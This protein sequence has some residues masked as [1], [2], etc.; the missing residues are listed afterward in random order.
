MVAFDEMKDW[1]I[2]GWPIVLMNNAIARNVVFPTLALLMAGGS[3]AAI[4][5][6]MCTAESAVSS[7][8]SLSAGVR[9][10][11]DAVKDA[12]DSKFP[13]PHLAGVTLNKTLDI[14][15][16]VDEIHGA[17]YDP[18]KGEIVF[19]GQGEI[20][21]NERIDMDD[22]VVAVRS[23]FGMNQDPGITFYSKPQVMQQGRLDVHYFGA[24]KN[25]E[26]GQILFEA[27]YLL[28]QLTLGI[29]PTGQQL[30]AARPGMAALG[31]ESF[32]DRMI[33]EEMSL[34]DYAVEFWFAPKE[35]EVEP[36][37]SPADASKS[38]V[39]SAM[40]M[41][42]YPRVIRVSDGSVAAD[43]Q[44][45]P[46]DPLAGQIFNV[47]DAFATNITNNY[48]DYADL[49][50]FGVLH[51]LKRLGR[52][53]SVVRW[54]RFNDIAVDLSF[55][56]DYV[57]QN[58]STPE[59]VDM[60]Q[61]CRDHSQDGAWASGAC[62]LVGKISGG[63]VYDLEY[64]EFD[65]YD[66]PTAQQN[67]MI[68]EALASAGR[69]LNPQ[70]ANDM[71]WAFTA[72]IGGTPT[73]LV[74]IA[75][76]VAGSEKDGNYNFTV[77]D[78]A[79]P[80]Q[81]GRPL[82]FTRYYDSF[83]SVSSGFGPG[84]SELPYTLRF[85]EAPSEFVWCDDP[86][87]NVVLATL[88]MRRDLI[89]V[90]REHGAT[91]L[92]Q[93]AGYISWPEGG[94]TVDRPY[95]LSAKTGDFIHAR[96]D[97]WFIYY[98]VNTNNQV[99]QQVWFQD[100]SLPSAPRYTADPYH[101]GIPGGG[102]SGGVEQGIWVDYQYDADDRLISIAGEGGVRLIQIDHDGDRI[103]RVW[104]PSAS[105]VRDVVYSY[106]DGRL[107]SATRSSGHVMQYTY[108]SN[109]PSDGAISTVLDQS[110]AETLGSVGA[111]LENRAA[112]AMAEGNP[113]LAVSVFYD[114]P[115]RLVQT[116]DT[117]GRVSAH[118][119]DEQHRL[120]SRSVQ[121]STGQGTQ[122]LGESYA[123]ADPNPLAGPTSITDARGNVTT[124][125]YDAAGNVTSI[126]DAQ[127]RTTT[128]ERGVDTADDMAVVVVTDAKGRKSAQKMDQFSRV[129][130]SYRRIQV[131][132]K[133][134][135]VENGT[136]TGY[137]NF[138]FSSAA[139][140][141]TSYAYDPDSGGVSAVT[142]DSADL[143]GQYPWIS[144]NETTQVGARDGFGQATLVTSPAGYATQYSYD[145]LA[146]MTAVKGPSD[147]AP[148]SF[149]YHAA[150]LA[151]DRVS[152]VSSAAGVSRH[153]YDVANR[154]RR[155]T[156]A[157]GIT[158]SYFYNMKNQ[159]ERVT[160]TAGS[161][162]LTTQYFYDN[163]GRLQT[164]QLPNGTRVTY[165]HDGFDRMI[166][167]VEQESGDA[168]TGNASPVLT[169][170]PPPVSTVAGGGTFTFDIDASDADDDDRR[171]SLVDAPEGMV[172][173]PQTGVI[174]WTP[175]ASQA[176]RHEVVVQVSDGNG[177]VD[178]V[179]FVVV[180]DDAFAPGADNCTAIPNPDQRDTDGDGYGNA[181]DADLNNDGIVNFSDLA[182]FKAAY[183]TADPHADF[184][185]D[186]IVDNQ[187]LDLLKSMFGQP[188]GPSGVA[189]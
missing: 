172:I 113:A 155:T 56:D 57:P 116:T 75:Q 146:R 51:K 122:T 162:T 20:P 45:T 81:A 153:S 182:I 63:I 77:V 95:Y 54:L 101:I 50:G 184:N 7:I 65:G 163:F 12:F 47:A 189:P 120:L 69:V 60:L 154:V 34:G 3:G 176:G 96:A 188:P 85:M 99:V 28:K 78:L 130:E 136:P 35:V 10:L 128:I 126:K 145:G 27:D 167:M 161:A 33:D 23:V 41:K 91:R 157:R 118:Q 92:F 148:V 149:N 14:L 84:W 102:S 164:K 71:K 129:V 80:N 1:R 37:V 82:A 134:P 38:F 11:A 76:T 98:R 62:L 147:V 117:L 39:F 142:R 43:G 40:T 66:Q 16:G 42:V 150:G 30:T 186:G 138:T 5:Q 94:A 67:A 18:R 179:D 181:C 15:N 119:R 19:I 127:N 151:Q 125:T 114:R 178:T 53:T 158:S 177:G 180:A 175:D 2:R 93:A 169:S 187:D 133:T 55:M 32:A 17:A 73:N 79:F 44:M 13:P 74:G 132:S 9:T 46:A 168:G 52:I 48:D 103:A 110:R 72:S 160:E 83:S 31:Y 90:D 112:T 64:E 100:K 106:T 21:L 159:V 36:Y 22:L 109:D 61:V 173:D 141:L 4:A 104:Y 86:Q 26:F 143:S 59:Q 97:G 165:S 131:T 140:H 183:G 174:S 123:Y 108:A 152:S 25:T 70:S 170:V 115:N 88:E 107:A 105:G 68:A 144:G 29:T 49:S 156:D 111:D 135:I 8:Y 185:G 121:A 6:Q 171:Y 58:V 166:S 24:T 124:L 87:C 137:F 89:L 139:G